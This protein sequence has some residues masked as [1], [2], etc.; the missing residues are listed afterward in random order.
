MTSAQSPSETSIANQTL[1]QLGYVGHVWQDT[2]PVGAALRTKEDSLPAYVGSKRG[3]LIQGA[4]SKEPLT[5]KRKSS[6]WRRPRAAEKGRTA[7]DGFM[8]QERSFHA[9]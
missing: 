2:N 3:K 1:S 4:C 8:T 6:I 5:I 9:K 7:R